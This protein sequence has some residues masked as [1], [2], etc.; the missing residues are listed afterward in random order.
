MTCDLW[1]DHDWSD[2]RFVEAGVHPTMGRFT[3]YV[4]RCTRCGKE[5]T[6]TEWHKLTLIQGA[7]AHGM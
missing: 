3:K 5:T 7:E 2:P 6:L 4:V 1:Q